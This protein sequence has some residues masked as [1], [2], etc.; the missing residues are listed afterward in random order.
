[1]Q[2]AICN[3]AA[4]SPARTRQFVKCGMAWHDMG[5]A[6]ADGMEHDDDDVER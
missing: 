3:A 4:G 1:M 2:H 6:L 5:G